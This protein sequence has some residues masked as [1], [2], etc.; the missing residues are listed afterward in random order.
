MHKNNVHTINGTACALPRIIISIVEQN[1]T[2]D[3][4]VILPEVLRPQMG[5]DTLEKFEAP[6]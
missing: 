1:Q 6:I 3:G 2:K 4:R 5:C